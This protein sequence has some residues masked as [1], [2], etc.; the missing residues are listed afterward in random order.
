MRIATQ[1]LNETAKRAHLPLGNTSLLN[2]INNNNSGAIVG[3]RGKNPGMELLSSNLFQR[4]EKNANELSRSADKLSE[5]ESSVFD[6]AR[7]S[8]SNEKLTEEID[9]FAKYFNSSMASAT[10]TGSTLNVYY[11]RMM[12]QAAIEH[13]QELDAIGVSVM[14]DGMLDVNK[15]RLGRADVDQIERVFGAGSGFM[16]QV[17]T[18]AQKLSDNA[19]AGAASFGNQYSAAGTPAS[20]YMANNYDYFG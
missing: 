5:K 3:S 16:R 13:R 18:L 17:T 11:R 4:L 10:G 14:E 8:G 20:A 2:Y 19:G 7:E 6:D 15:D 12:A 9:R 1:T